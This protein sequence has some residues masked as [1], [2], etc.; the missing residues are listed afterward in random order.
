MFE[1]LNTKHKNA[2][3]TRHVYNDYQMRRLIPYKYKDYSHESRLKRTDFSNGPVDIAVIGMVSSITPKESKGRAMTIVKAKDGDGTPF[4]ITYMNRNNVAPWLASISGRPVLF[5]GAF[6]HDVI[7]GYSAF[8]AD[9][10]SDIEHNLRIVPVY[11]KIKNLAAKTMLTHI[12]QALEDKENETIPA[13]LRGQYPDINTALTMAHVPQTMDDTITG[14]ARLILDDLV[15]F[16]LSMQMAYTSSPTRFVLKKT[17]ETQDFI[18]TLPYA[19]TGG[20]KNAIDGILNDCQSGTR[21]NTL[22]QGDV[23]C[24]KTIVA[25]CVM[26]CFE[27]NGY[28]SI[29]MAPTQILASQHYEELCRYIAPEKIAYFDGTIK[30][31][32][33]KEYNERI[34]SGEIRYIVGTTALLT[35]DIPCAN[36]GMVIV[37]EEHRFG[38]MQRTTLITDETHTMTMSATPI[39]RSL[40]SAVYGDNMKVFRIMEKPG[41][42]LETKTYYDDGARADRLLYSVLKKGQQAYVVCALKEEADEES[43]MSH[44]LSAEEAFAYYKSRFEDQLGYKVGLV[45]GATKP[46]E[47][48]RIMQEFKENKIQIL[49]STTV[50]EVGVNVPNANII[51]IRNA[52]RFGLATLHQ[53]RGRVGRSDKQA[54]CV[55]IADAPNRRIEVMCSTNDGFVIAEEDFKERKSGDIL[56]VRQSGKNRFIEELITYPDIQT[57]AEQVCRNMNLQDS[58]QHIRKYSIVYPPQD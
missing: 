4:T 19:L 55:L 7:Y 8:N 27:E 12:H 17:D 39:P 48:D 16:R 18:Q 9:F 46:A 5:T 22:I 52:E 36:I 57:M 34:A 21:S 43:N 15:Y 20:Q 6:S 40:A 14:K 30:E 26:K 1:T 13:N 56:G 10:T 58:M 35:S 50:I 11:T 37:D 24:G 54:Y 23:G 32:V 29:L 41:G 53:L 31:S 33:R 45:T 51:L 47:K 3:A 49:V 38:V 42:R 2:Y 28:Q 25:V 44:I